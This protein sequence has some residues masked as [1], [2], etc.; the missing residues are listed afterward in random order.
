MTAKYNKLKTQQQKLKEMQA[1]LKAQ[2]SEISAKSDTLSSQKSELNAKKNSIAAS[3]EKI[4]GEISE[5]QDEADELANTGNGSGGGS[6]SGGALAWPCP[7]CSNISCGFGWRNCPFH[8]WECHTGIDISASYG[9][10]ITAAASGT[11]TIASYYGSFGNAVKISHGGGI[12]TLYGHCSRLLVSSGQHVKKGQVIAKVGSTGNS[13]GPH[14]HFSVIK[15]GSYV[16][17]MN[18]L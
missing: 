17:P 7:S 15:N 4:S 9:A 12:C 1:D 18:Y 6:Y 16:D 10:S 3:N 13:T 8:G 14:L 11:V 2:K 5:L